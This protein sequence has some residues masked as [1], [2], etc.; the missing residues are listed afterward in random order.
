MGRPWWEGGAKPDCLKKP[1]L[2]ARSG[3]AAVASGELAD[4]WPALTSGS[5]STAKRRRMSSVTVWKFSVS[6]SSC[7]CCVRRKVQARTQPPVRLA[8]AQRYCLLIKNIVWHPH[9][10]TS[11]CA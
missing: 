9:R 10:S 8:A 1:K 4:T 11:C 2:E 6:L 7:T 3:D 5:P